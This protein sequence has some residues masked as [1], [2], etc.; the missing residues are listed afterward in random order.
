M[1][2]FSA[3]PTEASSFQI[4]QRLNEQSQQKG[5]SA[6]VCVCKGRQLVGVASK[7]FQ[8][9]RLSPRLLFLHL[10]VLGFWFLFKISKQFSQQI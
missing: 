6:G 7:M 5:L 9:L 10:L 3:L 2:F 1:F 8:N 4:P